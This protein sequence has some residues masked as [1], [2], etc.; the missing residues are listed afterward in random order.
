MISIYFLQTPAWPVFIR[1]QEE[2]KRGE[3]SRPPFALGNKGAQ[4]LTFFG[5]EANWIWIGRVYENLISGTTIPALLYQHH[6]KRSQKKPK[7]AELL[8]PLLLL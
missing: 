8:L 7:E 4:L 6:S 3:S 1:S 2:F 5:R